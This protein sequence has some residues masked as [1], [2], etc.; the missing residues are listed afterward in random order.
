[1]SYHS[2]SNKSSLHRQLL[3]QSKYVHTTTP[4]ES[5]RARHRH[6]RSELTSKTTLIY[7]FCY[8]LVNAATCIEVLILGSHI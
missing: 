6:R 1:M 3:L 8:D 7:G 5:T 2:L 4:P